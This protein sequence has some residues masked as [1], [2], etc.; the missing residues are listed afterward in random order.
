MPE[1]RQRIIFLE[2]LGSRFWRLARATSYIGLSGAGVLSLFLS[3]AT[4]GQV[5]QYTILVWSLFLI[6]GGVC[7]AVGHFFK[8]L[9]LERMG[10]PLLI[11]SIGVYGSAALTQGHSMGSAII[12]LILLSFAFALLARAKEVHV[13]SKVLKLLHLKE[14]ED[15]ANH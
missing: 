2:G 9:A 15:R 5:L 10:L 6:I 12:G 1:Q 14:R 13:D 8:V 7:C 11:S 3:P 4:L